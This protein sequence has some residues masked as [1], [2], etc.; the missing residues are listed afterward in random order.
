M[1]FARASAPPKYDFSSPRPKARRLSASA[2]TVL[3]LILTACASAEH[4]IDYTCATDSPCDIS[5]VIKEVSVASTCK[6]GS[7]NSAKNPFTEERTKL[8]LFSGTAHINYFASE[9]SVGIN[10]SALFYAVSP[11][12]KT[13]LSELRHCNETRQSWT[14]LPRNEEETERSTIFAVP[15]STTSIDTASFISGLP[16]VSIP[17]D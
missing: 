5:I 17:V 12:K 3:C 15:E 2:I 1:L 11:D 9:N 7:W 16:A 10:P 6:H 13:R 4:K 8:I 14:W